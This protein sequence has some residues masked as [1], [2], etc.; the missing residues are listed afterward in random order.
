[1]NNTLR[2]DTQSPMRRSA[3]PMLWISIVSI[4]MVFA[5]LTSAYLVRKTT[6]GWEEISL[7]SAFTYSTI[8]I[9]LSSGTIHWALQKLRINVQHLAVA[10]ILVTLVLG[11]AFTILQWIGF[12]QMVEEGIFFTGK[13]STT[14]G[15][16]IYVL[17]ITHIAHL[18]GGLIALLITLIRCQMRK[19]AN[20]NTLGLELTATYWH[21]LDIL[22]VYLYIFMIIA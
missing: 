4:C 10:G 6:G 8:I 14:S 22:W 11:V 2:I 18:A 21:F 19:Y 5:G 13:D 15:S 9:V 20:G 12:G 7:P 3:K 1:M 17:T 16:F